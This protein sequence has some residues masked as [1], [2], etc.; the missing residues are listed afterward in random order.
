MT[1]E[2][3]R[4]RVIRPSDRSVYFAKRVTARAPHRC[5]FLSPRD[6][7]TGDLRTDPT[8]PLVAHRRLPRVP[9]P[10]GD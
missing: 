2:D 4:I 1:Y 10:L 3:G 6:S 8:L 7:D 9:R 5:S